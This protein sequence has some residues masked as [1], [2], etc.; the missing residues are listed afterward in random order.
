MSDL[1]RRAGSY[2]PNLLDSFNAN[3][4]K[5]ANGDKYF[6]TISSSIP[7]YGTKS[8]DTLQGSGGNDLIIGGDG[9]DTYVFGRGDGVDTI[10]DSWRIYYRRTR[11]RHRI[12]LGSNSNFFICFPLNIRKFQ[13]R[14]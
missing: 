7:L 1:V 5:L 3:L 9:N 2:K 4:T 8:N 6:I 13:V 12:N 14:L 11:L 10:S